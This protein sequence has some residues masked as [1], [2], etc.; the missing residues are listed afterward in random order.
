M[1][2]YSY[3]YRILI[4]GEALA[5]KQLGWE[6]TV[7]LEEGQKPTIEYSDGFLKAR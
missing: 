2:N 4:A 3:R 1:K 5:R 6:P 7:K